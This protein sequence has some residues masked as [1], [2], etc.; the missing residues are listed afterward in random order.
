MG[1]G[2]STYAPWSLPATGLAT[3]SG[4]LRPRHRRRGR[5]LFSRRE[6]LQTMVRAGV[7][8]GLTAVG[9]IRLSIPASAAH[10]CVSSPYQDILG[11]CGGH[12]YSYSSHCGPSGV[13]SDTCN[14]LSGYHK[15]SGSYRN[16]PGDCYSGTDGWLWQAKP[17][18]GC[19]SS[20]CR[21]VRCHDG[22]KNI[23]GSWVHSICRWNTGPCTGC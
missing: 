21:S 18:P 13:Y 7:G 6:V 12:D 22:C 20:Q 1:Q 10:N 11:G 15:W 23:S 3:N 19:S 5:R 17:G 9:L 4:P 2:V 16:R 14:S 8:L